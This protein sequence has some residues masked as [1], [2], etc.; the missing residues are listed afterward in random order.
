MSDF[1]GMDAREVAYHFDLGDELKIDEQ[2]GSSFLR[3]FLPAAL[4]ATFIAELILYDSPGS[5]M[6]WEVNLSG[7]RFFLDLLPS[8]T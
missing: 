5:R 7:I 3:I 4:I 6:C 8:F 2:L 1:D